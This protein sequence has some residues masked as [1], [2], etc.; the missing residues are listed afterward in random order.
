MA[1]ATLTVL[2][3]AM[4]GGF[5]D[6]SGSVRHAQSL[7]FTTL[8]LTQLFNVLASR[9]EERSAFS[10]LFTNRWLWA[11][12]ALSVALQMLV[13]YAGPLQGAFQTE[14]LTLAEWFGCA[15]AGTTVLWVSEL[16]KFFRRSWR[17]SG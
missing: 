17:K 1:V 14:P 11:S 3:G 15:A 5:I 7:A 8:V 16:M 4:P 2:D 12:L 9:S 6:G 10:Q 13:I